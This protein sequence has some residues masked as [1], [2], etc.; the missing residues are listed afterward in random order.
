[1]P[2]DKIKPAGFK[3]KNQINIDTI[4]Y[5]NIPITKRE[6]KEVLNYNTLIIII[7]IT[8][9]FRLKILFYNNFVLN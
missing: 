7:T 8:L 2:L 4:L 9:D 5:T 6:L 1:M 3:L